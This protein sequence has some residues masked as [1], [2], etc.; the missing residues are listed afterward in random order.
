MR[1]DFGYAARCVWVLARCES[2][3]RRQAD[4]VLRNGFPTSARAN[5]VAVFPSAVYEPREETR[6]FTAGLWVD[7]SQ[8]AR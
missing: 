1:R 5:P 3:T 2:E 8:P 4:P 6:D 7:E